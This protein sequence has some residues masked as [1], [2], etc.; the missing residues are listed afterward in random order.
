MSA[1]PPPNSLRN[2]CWKCAA[3]GFQRFG[4]QAAAV[5]VDAVD[6]LLQRAF[7]LREILVLRGERLEACFQLVGFLKRIEVYAADVRQ[8]A[9][10]FGNFGFHLFAL[11]LLFRR[12]L[13]GKLREFDA[14]IFARDGLPAWRA[15]GG[16]RRRPIP[17]CAGLR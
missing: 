1:W 10:E 5:G 16:F 11:V 3:D 7:G 12:E 2:N 17:W 4:E 14:V 13:V 6:D 8:L 15:R 9:A